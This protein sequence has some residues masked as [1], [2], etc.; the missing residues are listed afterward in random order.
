V[1]FL[2]LGIAAVVIFTVFVTVFAASA[3]ADK[4]RTLPKWFWL[5][6]CFFVPV[7]GG[8]MYLIAGRPLG[9]NTRTT[10]APDDDPEFLRQLRKR[11]ENDDE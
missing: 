1:R 4:V 7:V 11:L 10:L 3:Q 9:S 5:L 8:L 2:I 6:L